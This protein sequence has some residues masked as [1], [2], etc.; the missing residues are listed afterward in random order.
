MKNTQRGFIMPLLL[1]LIAVLLVGGGVYVYENKKVEVP[2]V[3]NT[4]TQQ[5]DQVQQQTNTQTPPVAT[6][7]NTTSKNQTSNSVGTSPTTTDIEQVR[8]I[9]VEMRT[10]YISGDKDLV[11][12]YAT[13][14]TLEKMSGSGLSPKKDFVV[15]NIF[16]S[17]S[18]IVADVTVTT[19]SGQ[20]AVNPI[21]FIKENG[22]WKFDIEASQKYT[23]LKLN[24]KLGD[25]QGYADLVITGMT[26]NPV[27]PVINSKDTSITVTIKN[28]GTK[29][30]ERGFSAFAFLVEGTKS[31]TFQYT[32]SLP[33]VSPGE[34]INWKFGLSSMFGN[35]N[36]SDTLGKKVI[37]IELNGDHDLKESDYQNNTSL[38]TIEI[39]QN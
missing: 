36:I 35:L 19:T 8:K 23:E 6:P 25:P 33:T 24:Q 18:T 27:R 10:G 17:N 22:D 28:I 34:T 9:L 5:L 15:N 2:A 26:L 14:V 21:V 1:A 4:E 11:L 16:S 38:E 7:V 12:K 20:T 39:Y 32:D 13:K 29:V 30:T 31:T 37:K 3:V